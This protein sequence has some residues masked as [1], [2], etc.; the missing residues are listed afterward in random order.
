MFF[1]GL[2]SRR[3]ARGVPGSGS[4]RAGLSAADLGAGVLGAGVLGAGASGATTGAS[5]SSWN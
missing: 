4:C 1:V 3:S 2:R 5:I